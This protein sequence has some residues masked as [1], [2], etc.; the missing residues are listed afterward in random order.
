M[1]GL[2]A[3]N[4]TKITDYTKPEKQLQAMR[5][6]QMNGNFILWSEFGSENLGTIMVRFG[7]DRKMIKT[8]SGSN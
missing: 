6:I 4:P 7:S 1:N 8:F 2:I 5:V 3:P